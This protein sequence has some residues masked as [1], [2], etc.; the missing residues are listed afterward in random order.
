MSTASKTAQTSVVAH[1]ASDVVVAI[2]GGPSAG[3]A[4]SPG[5]R[6]RS[7]VTRATVLRA[8]DLL[9]G[10][11]RLDHQRRFTLTSLLT[12]ERTSRSEP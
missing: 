9:P 10:G 2:I 5:D 12:Q 3:S 11:L 4:S 7:E 1:R 6:T 8:A